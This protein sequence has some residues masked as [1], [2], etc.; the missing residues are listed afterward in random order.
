MEEGK[1]GGKYIGREMNERVR[2]ISMKRYVCMYV[3]K[4]RGL[5]SRRRKGIL[6]ILG[7]SDGCILG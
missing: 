3:I 6:G 2:R 4:D 1:E 7:E 5:G